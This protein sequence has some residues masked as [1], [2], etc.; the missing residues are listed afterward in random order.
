M[1]DRE[2]ERERSRWAE[3]AT[4]RTVVVTSSTFAVTAFGQAIA[5]ELTRR[6][7]RLL[8]ALCRTT[9]HSSHSH[10]VPLS[11]CTTSSTPAPAL[12]LTV[13]ASAASELSRN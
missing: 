9:N 1:R 7:Q 12:V 6:S 2:R 8:G 13:S 4:D 5:H 10:N 11:H 3:R